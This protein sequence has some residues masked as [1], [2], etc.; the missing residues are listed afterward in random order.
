MPFGNEM[1]LFGGVTTTYETDVFAYRPSMK[2]LTRI[3]RMPHGLCDAKFFPIGNSIYGMG[4]ESASEIRAPWTL[5][6]ILPRNGA[7]RHE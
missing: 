2:E 5:E 1:L 3:S 6:A 7:K 4:G